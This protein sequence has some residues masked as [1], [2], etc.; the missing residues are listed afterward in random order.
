MK[1]IDKIK[2]AFAKFYQSQGCSC[3]RNEEKYHLATEELGKL[4]GFPRYNDDSG[5]DF[6]SI[7]EEKL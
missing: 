2:I 4:L 1:K 5:Y 6:Y 3:C 7:T